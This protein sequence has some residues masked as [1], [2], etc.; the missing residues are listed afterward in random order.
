MCAVTFWFR[1][2]GL[3]YMRTLHAAGFGGGAVDDVVGRCVAR[4]FFSS[5]S[6]VTHA[7]WA[8]EQKHTSLAASQGTSMTSGGRCSRSRCTATS[9]C[10]SQV[11]GRSCATRR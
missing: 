11:A 10:T 8:V 6:P 5:S 7:G 1:Y 4:C 3:I 2:D 9:R